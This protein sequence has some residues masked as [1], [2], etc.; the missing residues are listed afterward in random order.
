MQLGYT[1]DIGIPFLTSISWNDVAGFE[2]CSTGAL[3]WW[4]AQDSPSRGFPSFLIDFLSIL[5]RK[6]SL[7]EVS[8]CD[9]LAWCCVYE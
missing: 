8:E 2:H 7:L 6:P 1:N 9:I 3:G 5:R 4:F